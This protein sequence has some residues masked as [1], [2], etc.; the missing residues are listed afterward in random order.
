MQPLP[1]LV[2]RKEWQPSIALLPRPIGP[3]I[4]EMHLKRVIENMNNWMENDQVDRNLLSLKTRYNSNSFDQ[5]INTATNFSVGHADDYSILTKQ[6]PVLIGTLLSSNGQ[7]SKG[8]DKEKS[9]TSLCE[10]AISL[11]N[12]SCDL[13]SPAI[14][15]K[16]EFNESHMSQKND[17]LR[18]QAKQTIMIMESQARLHVMKN[19]RQ[20]MIAMMKNQ[21]VSG[22]S[23]E[24][25]KS[26]SSF[27]QEKTKERAKPRVCKEQS[28]DYDND[29]PYI[30]IEVTSSNISQVES[31]QKVTEEAPTLPKKKRKRRLHCQKWQDQYT[32]LLQYK[33]IY[34]DCM[35]P[36]RY[37]DDPKLATWV[38]E[39]RKLYKIQQQGI[40][41]ALT[42]D[43]I[44]LLNEVSFVWNAHDA[45][46]EKHLKNLIEFKE[47]YG[48]LTNP[49]IKDPVHR[50]LG[51]W[52]R[53]QRYY[54]NRSKRG[55]PTPISKE[56]IQRLEEVGGTFTN[57][58]L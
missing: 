47:K 49:S 11:K 41:T 25:S 33:Q 26:V 20:G 17:M 54:R 6:K 45:V 55:L 28:H 39:Q 5:N 9:S 16:K 8:N 7:S 46:W 57:I 52:L 21:Q 50:K 4:A 18:L 43:R 13:K 30:M 2:N 36:R 34:G 56:R 14:D 24:A 3:M 38:D 1:L 40:D 35:V 51:L 12:E 27:I 58:I 48:P 29:Q 53:Q 32:R 31:H 42:D 15:S 44:K 22:S 19:R 10:D 37:R 23:N